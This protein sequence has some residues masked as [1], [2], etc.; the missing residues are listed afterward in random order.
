MTP[1]ICVS[2]AGSEP[3]VEELL[4]EETEASLPS[5]AEEPPALIT[6]EEIRI[7]ANEVRPRLHLSRQEASPI[8]QSDMVLATA[9][10]QKKK[11]T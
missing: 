2:V 7:T 8:F 9:K 5:R 4:Q 11:Q 6:L 3:D 1:Y 10:G